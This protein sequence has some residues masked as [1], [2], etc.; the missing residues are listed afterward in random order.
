[1]TFDQIMPKEREIG[2]GV[3]IFTNYSNP[4][5]ASECLISGWSLLRANGF[6]RIKNEGE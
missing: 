2:R 4:R 5:L 6:I 3:S 1:M